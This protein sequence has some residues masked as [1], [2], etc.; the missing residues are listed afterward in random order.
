ME[1]NARGHARQ[2]AR[3]I[4]HRQECIRATRLRCTVSTPARLICIRVIAPRQLGFYGNFRGKFM[5]FRM[6]GHA[7]RPPPLPPPS[8]HVE[9][10]IRRTASGITPSRRARRVRSV[11][12]N[13]GEHSREE[14]ASPRRLQF[15]RSR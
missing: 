5:S 4:M 8:P 3:N 14:C 6:S 1:R 15:R 7:G 9:C 10:N 13:I 12:F 2:C 11:T